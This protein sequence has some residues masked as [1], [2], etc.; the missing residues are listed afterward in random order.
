MRRMLV[1]GLISLL[2]VPTLP[3][4]SKRDWD[5]V[6]KLKAGAAVEVSLWTGENLSG[7]VEGVS[8]TG[9]DRRGWRQFRSAR[10][11]AA[12]LR[13]RKYPER[14]ALARTQF[15]QFQTMADSGYVG[16]RRNRRDARSGEGRGARE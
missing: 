15:A 4:R 2:L 12:R 13:P 7:E 10:G 11:L 1:T 3:A 9:A 6:K 8:D 16:R 5:N 14:G